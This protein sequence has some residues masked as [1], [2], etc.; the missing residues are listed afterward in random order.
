MS[1]A[2][3]QGLGERLPVCAGCHGADGNSHLP[4]VPSIAGQPKVFLENYLVLTR[5]GVRGSEVMRKLL[6]GAPDREIVALASHFSGLPAKPG[7]GPT[8]QAL[9]ERGRQ[10]AAK[11]HCGN[12]HSPD[13]RGQSQ[14]PRLAGQREEFLAEAMFAY[15]QNRWPGGDT[16]MAASLYGISD[17][18]IK[19]LAHFLARSK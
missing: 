16:I 12:C 4:G 11:N 18:D 10:V 2:G 17:A 8:D 5:E 6:H 7:G 15:R 19:A 1:A 13:Y 9:F 14:M 3:A